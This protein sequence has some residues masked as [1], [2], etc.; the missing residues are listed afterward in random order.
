V[1]PVDPLQPP[2]EQRV[3]FMETLVVQ[4]SQTEQ[5]DVLQRAKNDAETWLAEVLDGSMRTPFEY[6]YREGEL[7]AEDGGALGPIFDDAIEAAKRIRA[8]KP[9]L[10]FE[11]R[12]RLI[13][14]EEYREMLAMVRGERPNTMVVISD[15]PPE[16]MQ[17]K[18]D[19]GGYNVTRKQ[20]MLRVITFANGKLRM[21]SQSLDG[22][23]RAAL[24]NIYELFGD[25]PLSGELLNQRIYLDSPEEDQAYLTDRLTGIYD[26]NLHSQFG[27]EWYAGRREPRHDTYSFVRRQHELI[28]R[29]VAHETKGGISAEE[30]YN[31]AALLTKRF[32]ESKMTVAT[33]EMTDSSLRQFVGRIMSDSLDWELQKAG[34]EAR[35]SG[36]TFSGCGASAKPTTAGEQL[37][38]LGYG[39]NSE[40]GADEDKFGPLEFKCKKGHSNRRPRGKLISQC[41]F[42]G[43]KDSV[44]C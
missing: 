37:D 43:C 25:T 31:I 20:T 18:H 5:F 7:Y 24:E 29:F 6:T 27:G 8:E 1:S 19:V 41:W 3:F 15:F 12:R 44:G 21:Q 17:A 35:S 39:N 11:L 2:Q 13:E 38:E 16:L 30:R 4:P 33:S 36:K 40:T 42:P 10:A 22:S 23:N 34:D 14:R 28:G 9:E 26:R 32:E